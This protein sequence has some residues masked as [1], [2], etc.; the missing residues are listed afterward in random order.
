MNIIKKH[1]RLGLVVVLA[2]AASGC[3]YFSSKLANPNETST[4]REQICASLK[5]HM[6][7]SRN[8]D[9]SSITSSQ[10][11]SPADQARYAQ[12][13]RHYDCSNLEK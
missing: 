1:V 13:Y 9:S 10:Q 6:T 7:F 3:S 4:A 12:S 11:V 5:S 2:L 8:S